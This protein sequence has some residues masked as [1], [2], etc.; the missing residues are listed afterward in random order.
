MI[1]QSL[2][3]PFKGGLGKAFNVA[4]SKNRVARSI[5]D[6]LSLLATHMPYD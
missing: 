6:E 4:I 5:N 3:E 2:T 1:G